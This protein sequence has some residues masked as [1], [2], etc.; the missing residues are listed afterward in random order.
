MDLHSLAMDREVTCI[1]ICKTYISVCEKRQIKA[2][3][4]QS[5]QRSEGLFAILH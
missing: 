5:I 2:G 3:W 1:Y 4:A